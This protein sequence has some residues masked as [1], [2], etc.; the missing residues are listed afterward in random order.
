MIL[1]NQQQQQQKQQSDQSRSWF[2]DSLSLISSIAL[3][4]SGLS[5]TNH[6]V[7]LHLTNNYNIWHWSNHI[8]YSPLT[9]GSRNYGYVHRES[10]SIIAQ[11]DAT[12]YNFNIFLQT[13]L[14]VSDETLIHHQE[15]TQTVITTSA[16]GRT[17]FAT[18]RWRGWVGTMGTCI[19]NRQRTVANTVQTVPDV[20][21]T[22]WVCSWWRMRISSKTCRAVFRKII[23][24]YIVPSCWTIID[25]DSRCTDPW[26]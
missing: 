13:A 3:L 16:T 20:V 19:V 2:C 9:C 4:L 12:I 22:I 23:K 6:S 5:I 24:H 14:H 25:I 11:Q 15:H 10:M 21:I 8:C 18:V 17:V 7:N 26:T 1:N